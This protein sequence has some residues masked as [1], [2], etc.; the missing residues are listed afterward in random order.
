M[1]EKVN[2]W[3]KIARWAIDV[4]IGVLLTSSM[5]HPVSFESEV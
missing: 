4:L 5:R 2:F 3:L 1:N